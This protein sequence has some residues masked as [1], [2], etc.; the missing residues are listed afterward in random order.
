MC[1]QLDWTDIL[2]LTVSRV[3]LTLTL[4]EVPSLAVVALVLES[5]DSSRCCQ[6]TT[7]EM[8]CILFLWLI[9]RKA[10]YVLIASLFLVCKR[11]P[12]FMEKCCGEPARS[13]VCEVVC[14]HAFAREM[15]L[16]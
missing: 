12:V 6:G 9:T 14:L 16:L 7:R 15:T 2:H 8:S 11:A 4:L 1:I 3:E 10:A 5:E 13:V